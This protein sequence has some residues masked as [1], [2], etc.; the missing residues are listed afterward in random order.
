MLAEGWCVAR[1]ERVGG[2]LAG[3]GDVD[4]GVHA[5]IGAL[6]RAVRAAAVA[7]VGPERAEWMR[8]APDDGAHQRQADRTGPGGAFRLSAGAVSAGSLACSGSG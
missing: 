1:E 2:V 3:V 4:E 6:G 8:L 7:A 5:G